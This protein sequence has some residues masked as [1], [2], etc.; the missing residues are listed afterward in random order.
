MRI[1]RLTIAAV[2]G[3]REKNSACDMLHL[4]ECIFKD[5]VSMSNVLQ[6]KIVYEE[7]SRVVLEIEL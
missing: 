4:C 5:V 7:A 1:D 2:E 6:R 3:F